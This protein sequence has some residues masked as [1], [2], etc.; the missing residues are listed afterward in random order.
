MS[1]L[2]SLVDDLPARV[3]RAPTRREQR[4]A[5]YQPYSDETHAQWL[6]DLDAE[7]ADRATILPSER[8]ARPLNPD[9]LREGALADMIVEMNRR[10]GG[11]GMDRG[12]SDSRD[13]FGPEPKVGHKG[14]APASNLGMKATLRSYLDAREPCDR[15]DSLIRHAATA[16]MLAEQI[17]AGRA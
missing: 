3:H 9:A 5:E 11:I 1:S 7:A 17:A 13:W 8:R 15:Y 2:A 12:L 4:E 10:A 16:L 14:P 6:R